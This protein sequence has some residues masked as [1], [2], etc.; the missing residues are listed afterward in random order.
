MRH[1]ATILFLITNFAVYGLLGQLHWREGPFLYF[2]LTG[3]LAFLVILVHEL[4]H[5]LAARRYGRPLQ[6]F[7]VMP[8]E[9]RF[10]PMRFR[11]AHLD[12]VGGDIGGFVQYAEFWPATRRESAV[13]AFAGPAAN[14]LLASAALLFAAW[15]SMRPDTSHLPS[16]MPAPAAGPVQHLKPIEGTHFGAMLPS[17]EE[18]AR[19]LATS[20]YFPG[21][22]PFG[23]ILAEACAAL[24]IGTGIANLIPFKGSDGESIKTA[25]FPGRSRS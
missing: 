23:A 7:V 12:K 20:S 16:I 25:L 3:L 17:S 6:R 18:V 5:A 2:F 10:R 4:G 24:S 8:F 19:A 1:V 21:Q 15:L 14:F 11:M 13:I 22:K 9:L